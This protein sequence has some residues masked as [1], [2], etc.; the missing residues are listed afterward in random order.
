MGGSYYPPR[1]VEP[2]R[3]Y[4]GSPT[5]ASAAG[6]SAAGSCSPI[7]GEVAPVAASGAAAT[8]GL[9]LVM[10][11]RSTASAIRSERSSAP[12]SS[13]VSAWSCSRGSAPVA[14]RSI[15]YASAR[16]PHASSRSSSPR[17]SIDARVSA[18][19]FVR[20]ASSASGS[21]RSTRSYVGAG[22]VT[23]APGRLAGPALRAD[24]GQLLVYPVAGI[25]RGDGLR[26]PPASPLPLAAIHRPRRVDRVVE[27]LDVERVHRER[28]LPQLLVRAGVLRQDR[29]ALALVDDRALLR[30]QV[31]AV[32]HRVYDQH[33]VVLEGGDRLLE[34]VAQLQLDRHPVGG[35]VP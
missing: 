7:G 23:L 20:V 31:H 19:I 35:A 13:A 4:A 22:N 14:W 10:R 9:S 24:V 27:L 6:S 26:E 11:K 1:R 2:R 28:V 29:H 32:E 30:H 18:R 21:S 25:P 17:A 12:G 3:R 33:V 15:G 8:P 5:S 16:S 34:V